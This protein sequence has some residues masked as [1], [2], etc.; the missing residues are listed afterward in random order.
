LTNSYGDFTFKYLNADETYLISIPAEDAALVKDNVIHLAKVD[1][2]IVKTLERSGN[3]FVY[4][5]LPV[6]LIVLAKET[7]E[8]DPELKIKNFGT[9]SDK[10]LTVIED[11]YYAPNSAEIS[12]LSQAILDKIIRAMLANP[13]LKLAIASHTDANGDDAYNMSLSEKRAHIVQQYFLSKGIAKERMTAKGYGETMIKNRCK[14]GVDCS[15]LEHELN[16][17]TEFKFTK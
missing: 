4:K 5:V 13:A 10:E 15:E 11:I 17:R 9:S 8:E 1:G 14:N 7:E 12:D 16:R 2:T 3:S 6:E